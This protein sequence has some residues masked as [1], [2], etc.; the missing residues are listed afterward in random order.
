MK[1]FS[2][3]ILCLLFVFLLVGCQDKTTTITSSTTSTSSTSTSLTSDTPYDISDFYDQLVIYQE[4]M[5]TIIT[6]RSFEPMAYEFQGTSGDDT[7]TIQRDE[8]LASH[9]NSSFDMVYD[10]YFEQLNTTYEF[11]SSIKAMI[12]GHENIPLYEEFHPQDNPTNTFRFIL[13]EEGY[14][15]IDALMGSNHSYLKIGLDDDLLVYHELHYY[16]ASSSLS[17][18]ENL[19]LEF[20][21]FKFMENSEAVYV[22]YSMDNSSLRYTSIEQ[23]EQFTIG[24]GYGMIEGPEEGEQGYVL[25]LYDRE[26]NAQIYLQ[27]ID[28]EIISETYDIFDEYGL[29]YRYDDYESIGNTINLNINFVTATG[30]DY[31]V[32]SEGSSEEIDP[33]TGIFLADGTKIY[34]EWFNYSYTPTYGHL[35]LR[36]ELESKEELTNEVFSLNQYGLNLVHPKATIEYFNQVQLSDFYQIKNR[37]SIDNLNYFADDLHQELYDYIDIDIRNDIEGI[38][39]EPITTTG[40]VDAFNDAIESFQAVLTISPYYTGTGRLTTQ[41]LD[42]GEVVSQSYSD[43][44]ENFDLMSMFF[45]SYN[46]IH[47]MGLNQSYSYVLDGTK[48]KLI[49]FEIN[50]Q[51]VQYDILSDVATYSNFA[52]AY[53]LLASSGG[54]DEVIHITQVNETTFELEVTTKYLN[55]SGIDTSLLFEQQGITGLD[56]QEIII[57]Y[58]FASDYSSYDIDFTISNLTLEEYEVKLISTSSIIIEPALIQSPLDNP[59]LLFHLPNSLDQILFTTITSTSRFI[60]NDGISYMEL[61]VE[62][63]EYSIDLWD[64]Y[65]TV[66]FKVYNAEMEEL[67]YDG[68]F[69]AIT[70]GNYYIKVTSSDE[71]SVFINVTYNPTP[72]FYHFTLDDFDS[73]ISMELGLEGIS[74]STITVPSSTYD[75]VMVINQDNISPLIEN[76]DTVHVNINL[77]DIYYFDSFSPNLEEEPKSSPAY[78][79]LPKNREIVL[80]LNGYFYGTY[81][82]DYAYISVPTGSFDNTYDW[83]DLTFTPI[84]WMTEESQVAHV[85]FSITEAGSY[86]LDTYYKD[87]GY[88]YQNAMLYKSDGTLVSYDWRTFLNLQP[89]EYFIE[90]TPGYYSDLFVLVIPKIVKQS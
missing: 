10:D 65:G 12:E 6:S 48:G 7:I 20:N 55:S 79:Y 29:V 71:Q 14:I 1:K 32:A 40:D 83:E 90:Y 23:D 37:F 2:S 27:V 80:D 84:L 66:T 26:L 86:D 54:L 31:V 57:T 68:R 17:I 46:V 13:S 25:N 70:E 36:I 24:S 63:G 50:N 49:E 21:Y 67:P 74:G 69:T 22:N 5:N 78:I 19:N 33:L 76:Y 62:P 42:E 44:Y 9:Y 82:F 51:V 15:L 72:T 43:S 85:D 61:F 16:Y 38:N 58:E 64:Y 53:S 81:A 87:F 39:E 30:W 88:S 41:I 89:G 18:K 11:V 47:G 28:D 59:S 8:I 60:V 45:S 75:R 56:D 35:G 3:C 34:D 4:R 52:T 77:E 73:T